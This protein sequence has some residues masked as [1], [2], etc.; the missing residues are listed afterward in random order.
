M[1]Y[2]FVFLFFVII[3]LFS[4]NF[5]N[6]SLSLSKG[7]LNFDLDI[8]E[9]NCQQIKIFSEDYEG[10]INIRDVWTSDI[11]QVRTKEYKM[12]AEDFGIDISYDNVSAS[13]N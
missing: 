8:N 12:V 6:A 1:R 10:D 13:V 2:F 7:R 4:G 5:V 9:K 3:I 11:S